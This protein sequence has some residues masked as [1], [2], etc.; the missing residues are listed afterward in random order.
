[1]NDG[2]NA[3]V[4]RTATLTVGNAVPAITTPATPSAPVVPDGSAVSVGLSFADPGTNDT[5]TA[6]VNWGDTTSSPGTV[7]ETAG[8]GSVSKSHTYAAPGLYTVTVTV[9]DDNG[10]S[11]SS[12]TVIRVNSSPTASAG[13]PYAGRGRQRGRR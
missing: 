8:S 13:G 11:A 2:I 10:G 9:T 12:T 7:T 3:P 6:T 1:M 4:V 5:H